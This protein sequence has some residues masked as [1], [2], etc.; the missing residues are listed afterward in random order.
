MQ[1]LA[2]ILNAQI[3][4]KEQRLGLFHL[5]NF[6]IVVDTEASLRFEFPGE[7]IVRIADVRSQVRQR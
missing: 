3:R 1:P 7:V 2:D 6:D 5:D 4:G